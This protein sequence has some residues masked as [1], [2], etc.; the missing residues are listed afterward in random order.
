[1]PFDISQLRLELSPGHH[2]RL[3]G[4]SVDKTAMVAEG[5]ATCFVTGISPQNKDDVMNSTLLAQ[6]AANSKHNRETEAKAWYG[7]YKYVL[8]H[9]GWVV[10]DFNFAAKNLSDVDV[11]VN[12]VVIDFMEAYLDPTQLVAMKNLIESLRDEKEPAAKIFSTASS[13][14]KN[15]NFQIGCCSQDRD[16][17]FFV[18]IG[19][20]C[21]FLDARHGSSAHSS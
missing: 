12:K 2:R 5:Q 3:L 14:G 9:V 15:A 20:G 1:M 10:S 13:D 6:L 8:E 7:Y 17:N 11:A 19:Y 18:L 16:S 4:E 21:I